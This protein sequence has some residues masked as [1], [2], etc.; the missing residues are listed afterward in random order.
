M[1]RSHVYMQIEVDD[2]KTTTLSCWLY[3]L[4][5]YQDI[6]RFFYEKLEGNSNPPKYVFFEFHM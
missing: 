5:I 1:I 3:I 2:D 4:L 6:F